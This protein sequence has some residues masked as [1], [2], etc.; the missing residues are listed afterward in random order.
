MGTLVHSLG[1]F[2]HLYVYLD[3]IYVN[4]HQ[5]CNSQELQCFQKKNEFS[6]ENSRDLSCLSTTENEQGNVDRNT[7]YTRLPPGKIPSTSE[8]WILHCDTVI[9]WN[10]TTMGRM[11]H[12][13]TQQ[14][15]LRSQSQ[16]KYNNM[17]Q[18]IMRATTMVS[19][20]GEEKRRC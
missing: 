9:A 15:G 2:F 7:V 12:D 5:L 19:S 10:V 16:R 17:L 14:H 8:S 1:N 6:E 18:F 11:Y 3:L 4:Q 20:W 13:Q